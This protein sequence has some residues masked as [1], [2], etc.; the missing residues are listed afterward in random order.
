MKRMKFNWGTGILFVIVLFLA[1]C[2]VFIIYSQ[3]QEWS[4]VEKDYYPKELKYEEVLVKMRNTNALSGP[5]TA[6]VEPAS[7]VIRFPRDFAGKALS[8]TLH[9][10]RP[11][12]ESMDVVIPLQVDTSLTQRVPAG[13][14]RRGRYVVK[15]DWVSEGT[16][17]YK[18]QDIYVP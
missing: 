15:I 13:K 12:A 9:I 11:S 1:A 4:L 17:F 3:N 6:S 14:L 5:V 16:G 10:Y 7:L 18:E 2:A 8:G